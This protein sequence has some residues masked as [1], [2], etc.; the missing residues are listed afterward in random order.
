MLLTMCVDVRCECAQQRQRT[1]STVRWGSRV[2]EPVAHV[3]RQQQRPRRP[4]CIHG[5]L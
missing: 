4:P 1:W 2:Q 3:Q 5:G